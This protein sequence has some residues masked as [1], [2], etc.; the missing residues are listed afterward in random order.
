MFVL[1]EQN[2]FILITGDQETVGIVWLRKLA[3]SFL[4]NDQEGS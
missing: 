4:G 2:L 1:K 3:W